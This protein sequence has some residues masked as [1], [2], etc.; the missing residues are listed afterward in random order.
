MKPKQ[1]T[2]TSVDVGLTADL[3]LIHGAFAAH[4]RERGYAEL[5]VQGYTRNLVR[6]AQWLAERGGCLKKLERAQVLQILHR[7]G[8]VD[9]IAQR[10]ALH[11]WLKHL[12]RY[13]VRPSVGWQCWVEDFVDFLAADKGLSVASCK[14]YEAHA[15]AFLTWR[16]GSGRAR[17]SQVRTE[18]VRRFASHCAEGAKP[19]FAAQKLSGL[20]QFLRFVQLRGVCTSL[21]VEAV[22][23]LANFG[24]PVP[25]KVVSR[26]QRLQLLSSFPRHLPVGQRDYAMTLCLMELG[27]RAIE[28]VHLRLEDIDW[29]HLRITILPAKNVRRGRELPLPQAVASALRTYIKRDRP[30]SESNRIFLRHH[31]FLGRPISRGIVSH[32]LRD[33]FQRSALPM[34]LAGT[35]TLRH[36]FATRLYA[37]GA[38]LK[39]IADVLGHED[40]RTSTKYTHTDL[41]GLRRLALPWP[42][43]P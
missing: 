24:Q 15:R 8:T 34:Q 4:L 19:T 27:L 36:T 42:V 32:M 11:Q 17:W 29:R 1:V 13:L 37:R 30:P 20:R 6:V 21:L 41:P 16:F 38:N 31:H 33:A 25:R 22:P 3:Q 12:G 10:A 26:G 39:Q 5:T 14:K 43:Q 2:P 18:D 23:S 7:K 35:H 40:I 28:V 9:R